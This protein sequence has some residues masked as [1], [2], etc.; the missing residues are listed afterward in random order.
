ML[1]FLA[2]VIIGGFLGTM[3]IAIVSVGKRGDYQ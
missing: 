2:G 3:M 1:L